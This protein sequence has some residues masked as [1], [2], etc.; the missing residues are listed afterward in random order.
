MYGKPP[1]RWPIASWQTTTREATDRYGIDRRTSNS[2]R[3]DC[4]RAHR[5]IQHGAFHENTSSGDTSAPSS[6]SIET[7][8]IEEPRD[9]E[10]PVRL[11]ATRICHTDI[12]MCDK[13]I[14]FRNRSCLAMEDAGIVER[15]GKFVTKVAVGDHVLMTFNSCDHCPSCQHDASTYC[16]EFFG[17]NFAGTRTDGTTALSRTAK[18]STAISSGSRVCDI[19]TCHQTNVVRYGAMFRSSV[20]RLWPALF[21]RQRERS[22]ETGS[23][24]LL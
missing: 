11:V 24:R 23:R 10:I 21:G 3:F 9:D 6:M 19:R 13:P 5:V 14:P 1:S 2:K 4:T 20:S 12:A 18:R 15:V 17:Y 7:L 22:A 8:T 16:H